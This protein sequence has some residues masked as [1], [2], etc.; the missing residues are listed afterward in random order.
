[1]FIGE[2][3]SWIVVLGFFLYRR[4]VSPRLSSGASPL[5]AGGYDPVNTEE[6]EYDGDED[7]LKTKI[8]TRELLT[9]HAGQSEQRRVG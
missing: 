2:M 6:R 3:G 1:M 7:V 9:T 8:E 4:Y 5:L